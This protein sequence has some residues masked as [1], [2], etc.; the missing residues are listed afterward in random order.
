MKRLLSLSLF[1]ACISILSAQEQITNP[2]FEQWEGKDDLEEPVGWNA[3]M[4]ASGSGLAYKM[5]RSKRIEPSTDTRPGSNGSKSLK[6]HSKDL[7]GTIIVGS[8]STG[9]FNVVNVNPADPS[10]YA[11][12]K[13]NDPK[14]HQKFTGKPKAVT[15]WAK[16]I[17]PDKQFTGC[18]GIAIHDNTEFNTNDFYQQTEKNHVI[19]RAFTDK[20]ESE[21]WKQYTLPF[22][23]TGST[24]DP[25][26]IHLIFSTNAYSGKGTG[27]DILYID[28]IEF[29]Y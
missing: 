13:I 6:M 3:L 5:G 21:T 7:L 29:I 26:Y 8:I 25:V 18:A 2:G 14:F 12:T 11:A 23:Y 4:T 17:T 1:L 15:F 27:D 28:D 19:A 24:K 9:Q 20:I 22:V 16:F 10:N